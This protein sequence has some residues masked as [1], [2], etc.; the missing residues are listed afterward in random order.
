MEILSV[1]DL[2]D[3]SAIL[4]VNISEEENDFFI[5]YAILDILKKQLQREEESW[6]SV[7]KQI[8]ERFEN[9]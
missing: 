9:E 3:G 6:E 2:P 4:E 7:R 5:E 1:K 8:A